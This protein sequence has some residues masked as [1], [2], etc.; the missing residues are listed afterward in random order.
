MP[1]MYLLLVTSTRGFFSSGASVHPRCLDLLLCLLVS[2][3]TLLFNGV[4][5]WLN[6]NKRILRKKAEN[7]EKKIHNTIVNKYMSNIYL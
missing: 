7:I 6:N 2:F 3:L 4:L 1:Q 5:D